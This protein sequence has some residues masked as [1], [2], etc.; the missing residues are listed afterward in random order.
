MS[1]PAAQHRCWVHCRPLSWLLSAARKSLFQSSVAALER[2]NFHM[3]SMIA[4]SPSARTDSDG[5]LREI[6]RH[7][8]RLTASCTCLVMTTGGS[9]R[10][11]S[12]NPRSVIHVVASTM[13]H[14]SRFAVRYVAA[15]GPYAILHGCTALS[16]STI[17]SCI[18]IS[19]DSVE[20]HPFHA[21]IAQC[22][23]GPLWATNAGSAMPVADPSCK[24]RAMSMSWPPKPLAGAPAD[25]TAC[26]CCSN[27]D[28]GTPEA[29]C[30]H[31]KAAVPPVRF[32]L[33]VSTPIALSILNLGILALYSFRR[34]LITFALRLT[35]AAMPKPRDLA[36]I[37]GMILCLTSP[38]TM[39]WAKL[40]LVA[41]QTDLVG[42]ISPPAA[43]MPSH[44]AW[45]NGTRCSTM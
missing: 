23:S 7:L 18:I 36:R 1:H 31:T 17:A 38:V 12:C 8:H 37:T 44:T 28:G 25:A 14:L 22:P 40:G 11:L 41:V 34:W 30:P 16:H 29:S 24:M 4:P 42:E 32:S 45:V 27:V 10:R 26:L 9:T 13:V 39:R 2:S 35:P 15:A 6:A 43:T 21:A 20:S 5:N 3:G 33:A 19:S